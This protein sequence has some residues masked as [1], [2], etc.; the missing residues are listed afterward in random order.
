M[1]ILNSLMGNKSDPMVVNINSGKLVRVN[2]TQLLHHP[3]N[4]L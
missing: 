3:F 2:D 4:Q 1:N